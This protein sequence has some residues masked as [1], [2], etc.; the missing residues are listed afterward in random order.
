[1]DKIDDVWIMSLELWITKGGDYMATLDIDGISLEIDI[2]A[3]ATE[4]LTDAKQRSESWVSACCPFHDDHNPSFAVHI[5]EGVYACQACGAKGG[6][7]KL[8]AHVEKMAMED[9][10]RELIVRYGRVVPATW[11]A[12]EL[13][14]G[15]SITRRERKVIEGRDMP[16]PYDNDGQTYLTKRGLSPTFASLSGVRFDGEALVFPYY[17]ETVRLVAYKHRFLT[18]KSFKVEGTTSEGV[19]GYKLYKSSYVAGVIAEYPPLIVCEGEFDA[20]SVIDALGTHAVAVGGSNVSNAQ[21][22]L[23]RKIAAHELV[24]FSDNDRAGRKMLDQVV[25]ALGA[26]KTITTVDWSLTSDCKDAND[27]LVK[28]GP[29]KVREMIDKRVPAPLNLPFN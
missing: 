23:L 6:F 11:K 17:S 28:Y 18:H 10:E 19:F 4:R 14:F 21:I 15:A 26:S 20:L 12:L 3:W 27:V 16:L 25:K 7:A 5:D 13:E 29:A 1:V 24:V 8:F 22:D 2:V 9:A